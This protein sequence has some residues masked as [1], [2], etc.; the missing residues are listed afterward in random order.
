MRKKATQYRLIG[1]AFGLSVIVA[2]GTTGVRA[3]IMQLGDGEERFGEVILNPSDGPGDPDLLSHGDRIRPDSVISIDSGS[4]ELRAP[5]WY[6]DDRQP[7]LNDN[8]NNRNW[9]WMDRVEILYYPVDDGKPDPDLLSHGD[10]IVPDAIISVPDG[11]RIVR[12]PGWY[13]DDRRPDLGDNAFGRSPIGIDSF[14]HLVPPPNAPIP[15]PGALMI[16]LTSLSLVSTRRR[17]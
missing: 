6:E 9:L 11:D 4:W 7:D 1:S 10:R 3:D 5:G 15:T 16:L 17:R 8:A 12:S 2:I 14:D 13:E